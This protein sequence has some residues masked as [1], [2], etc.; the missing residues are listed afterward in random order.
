MKSFWDE[1]YSTAGYVYGET[2]NL[3]FKE[4]ISTLTPC[5][6]LMPAEGEGRNAVFAATLGWDVTAFD[7]S[8]EG[9]R[10][11][12]SLAQKHHVEITY[13][14]GEVSEVSFEENS[15]DAI[16]LIFAH[17]PSAQRRIYHR[18]FSSYLKKGGV[19][20]LEAFSKN[21]EKFQALNPGIGGPKDIDMRY[22]TAELEAD[23]PDF[24]ILILREEEV[25]LEEG[26]NH[27]GIGSVI[28]FV[29]VKR[30]DSDPSSVI[31][32]Q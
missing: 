2:P 5:K 15:F 20:I 22:T 26:P 30:G 17:F 18:R 21:H 1:R 13:K 6:L 8:E 29:G 25:H 7:Q 24:D 4:Q 14:V 9:R 27:S 11:A 23:F 32:D 12:I 31:R 19:I 10:K 16:G 28:R 3:F